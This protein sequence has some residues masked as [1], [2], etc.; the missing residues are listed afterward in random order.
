MHNVCLVTKRLIAFWVRGKK[1]V[2]LTEEKKIEY[3]II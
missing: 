3:P 1:D 2:R